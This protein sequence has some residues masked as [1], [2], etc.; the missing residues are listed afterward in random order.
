VSGAIVSGVAVS[1]DSLLMSRPFCPIRPKLKAPFSGRRGCLHY[2]QLLILVITP[3]GIP[4]IS[5]AI[6]IVR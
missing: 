1:G 6:A 3:P 5:A 2:V 4:L